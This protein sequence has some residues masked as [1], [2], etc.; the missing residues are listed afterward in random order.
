MHAGPQLRGGLATLTAAIVGVIANL[1]LWFALHVLFA[2]VETLPA[3]PVRLMVP[4]VAS[5]DWQAAL[6]AALSAVLVF[7]LKR[8]VIHVIG[9]AALGGLATG[10]IS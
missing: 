6:L 7:R 10:L 9:L 2:R 3:G 8:N 4:V 5:L 1:S